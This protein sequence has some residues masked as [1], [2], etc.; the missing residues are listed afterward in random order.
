[1][2]RLSRARS[3]KHILYIAVSV[4]GLWVGPFGLA[5]CSSTPD[6]YEMEPQAVEEIRSDIGNVG[7]VVGSYQPESEVVRPARGW[8]GGVKRGFVIGAV[9][10]VVIG[11]VAPVPGG[12]LIGVLV[13]PWTA[14]AGSVYGAFNSVPPEQVDKTEA[15]L[16]EATARLRAMNLRESFGKTVVRLGTER[17]GGKFIHLSDSGPTARDEVVNYNQLKMSDMDAVLEITSERSGL[18]GPLSFDPPTSAFLELRSRLIRLT[19]HEVVY[20]QTLTCVSDERTFAEWAENEG[21]PFIGAFASC[22]PRLAEKVVD[23]F[24]LVYPITSR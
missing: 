20:E 13:A 10:P 8:W 23:D 1:M 4:L 11:A 9:T 15:A 22:I 2:I 16:N 21:A 14:A 18:R 12:T 3:L 19:N 24:F 7:V 5:G 17:T 6:I